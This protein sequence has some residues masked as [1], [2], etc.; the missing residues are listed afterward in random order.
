VTGGEHTQ[1]AAEPL[2]R[3]AFGAQ[4]AQVLYLTAKLGIADKLR[5]GHTTAAELAGLLR[6][7]ALAL[8]RVLRGLVV[9]GACEERH[10]SRFGLTTLGQHLRVDHPESVVARVILNVEVHHALWGDL[11]DTVKTGESASHRV[12]GG[13]FYEHLS[14]DRVAGALFDRAMSGGG[15]IQHR[16]RPAVE[17]YDFGKF[18]SI[19]DIG[20]GNGTLMVETLSAYPQPRGTV[21]DV[22]RLAPAAQA[23]LAAAGLTQRCDFVA[24]D[25]FDM[26][27]GGRDAY[28]LSNFVNSLSDDAAHVILRNCRRA[29][30]PDGK[31]L[32]LEWVLGDDD[33]ERESF[34]Y[35]DTVTMDLV[36]LAAFGSCGGRL[37]KRSEFE[38][39][40]QAAGFSVTALIPTRASICVIEAEPTVVNIPTA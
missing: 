36:M 22:P 12:F 23:M 27:P 11:L 20:G 2:L 24:G 26:V 29:I 3:A 19:V 8:E 9:L 6:V 35:W 38:S 17:A 37:R 18:R 21:F 14:Q 40:L 10:G 28:I 16:L 13:P 34:R 7:D 32:L 25:A 4:S 1:Q 30:S 5:F 31:L 39:L 33:S 15:W